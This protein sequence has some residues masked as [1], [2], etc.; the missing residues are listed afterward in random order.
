[1]VLPPTAAA[2]VLALTD[3][4]PIIT[5]AIKQKPLWAQWKYLWLVFGCLQIEWTIRKWRGF[6]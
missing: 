2:E 1:L 4:A 5:E 3:L 6:S